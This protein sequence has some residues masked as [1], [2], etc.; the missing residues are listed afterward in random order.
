M[1]PIINI[2]TNPFDKSENEKIIVE[3]NSLLIDFLKKQFPKGF[4]RNTIIKLN[5]NILK[6]ENY[7]V[8]L[9]KND[10]VDIE[11]QPEG[12][13][14]L[15]NLAVQEIA[16]IFIDDPEVPTIEQPDT[17]NSLKRPTGNAYNNRL[18]QNVAR[19]GEPI[20][21]Q[22]GKFKWFPDLATK[23][24]IRYENGIPITRY[25]LCLGHGEHEINDIL[26]GNTSVLDTED[27]SFTQYLPGTPMTEFNDKV[28]TL[29]DMQNVTFNTPARK[30]TNEDDAVNFNKTSQHIT[31]NPNSDTDFTNIF[32]IGDYV[33]VEQEIPFGPTGIGLQYNV[34]GSFEITNVTTNILTVNI[35]PL[36]D[37]TGVT[38]DDIAVT[39][40]LDENLTQN[41]FTRNVIGFAT[42]NKAYIGYL[43]NG[44]HSGVFTITPAYTSGDIILEVDIEA[45]QGTVAYYSDNTKKAPFVKTCGFLQKPNVNI[46]YRLYYE[47]PFI[48]DTGT[49]YNINFDSLPTY[50]NKLLG[51]AGVRS[52]YW[53]DPTTITDKNFP[54]QN[55]STLYFTENG[56]TIPESDISSINYGSFPGYQG[57]VTFNTPKTG[58]IKAH[59]AVIHVDAEPDTFNT[60]ISTSSYTAE[61]DSYGIQFG[62]INNINAAQ[63]RTTFQRSLFM[64][65][66]D[67]EINIEDKYECLLQV[68]EGLNDDYTEIYDNAKITRIKLIYPDQ[69]NYPPVDLLAVT[70]KNTPAQIFNENNNISV[71]STRKLLQYD[72]NNWLGPTSTRSISWTFAD[73]WMSTYGASRSDDFLNLQQLQDLNTLFNTREDTFDAVFDSNS[74]C[75]EAL[76]KVARTGRCKVIFDNRIIT[77]IRDE[78]KSIYRYAFSPN[79]IL[80][81]TFNLEFNIL[82]SEE[83][84]GIKVKYLD[85]D[86]NYENNFVLST[87]N[88]GRYKEID[89]F[90]VVNYNQAWRESQFLEAQLLRLRYKIKFITDIQGQLPSI[91]DYVSISHDLPNWGQS[92]QIVSKTG[93]TITTTQPLNFS[94]GSQ[95][96]FMLFSRPNGTISGPHIV[97]QGSNEFECILD[98]DVTDFTFITRGDNQTPTRYQFGPSTNYNQGAIVTKI[99]AQGNNTHSIECVPYIPEIYTADTG[100]PPAKPSVL[101]TG[102]LPPN[103]AGLVLSNNTAGTVIAKWNPLSNIDNYK[104]QTSTDNI[105]W[106]D[107]STP[108]VATETI[109]ATGILYVR[110]ASVINLIV[111]DY[112]SNVIIAV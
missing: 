12:G 17:L 20:P 32:E 108:T 66:S 64:F 4:N 101:P 88:L 34:D 74:T 53:V 104:V 11:I 78:E 73:I 43:V 75:F 103:I 96:Y 39:L 81:N 55:P 56:I 50:L 48:L 19:I 16:N 61:R 69:Q 58:I 105:T 79:N 29:K 102:A 33:R 5:N 9:D 6:V 7:D 68:T 21:S 63:T 86:N 14:A 36:T 97:T 54:T 15:A 37:W 40:Y 111:G 38:N 100:T 44:T 59:N 106:V 13:I 8:I 71:V 30:F 41:P 110:V 51:Q 80:S 45:N 57:S 77:L 84:K 24:Y 85:E 42:R 94:T 1:H 3:I 23:P 107:F 18:Q 47:F 82:D 87:P 76:K 72:G 90:G 60:L 70:I 62:E 93:T 99:T 46:H 83:P 52:V 26:I 28:H 95:P 25:L 67:Y 27:L 31:L 49:T 22:Y 112:T 98:T 89:F 109:L 92:G 91:G 65:D 10:I 2:L 35:D